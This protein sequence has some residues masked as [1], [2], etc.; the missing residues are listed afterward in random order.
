MSKLILEGITAQDLLTQV[1]EIIKQELQASYD[2]AIST[3]EAA[4]MLSCSVETIINHYKRGNLTPVSPPGARYRWSMNQI[5][6]FKTN[7]K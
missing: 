7:R 4:E 5:I 3:K 1:R 6:N 2:R